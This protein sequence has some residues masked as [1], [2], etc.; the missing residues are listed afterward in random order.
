M[1]LFENLR[2]LVGAGEK[3]A[4][5]AARTGP[6]ATAGPVRVLVATFDGDAGGALQAHVHATLNGRTSM[7][8][9]PLGRPMAAAGGEAGARIA[10]GT[11][12]A[13]NALEK[14]GA[15]VLLWGEAVSGG[16][17][18]LRF[19]TSPAPA[20]FGSGAPAATE[21]LD[22]PAAFDDEQGDV[23]EMVVLACARPYDED[24]RK[25]RADSLRAA[26]TAGMRV[27]G[28]NGL[29][30]P[31]MTSVQAWLGNIA[32][33]P[34]LRTSMTDVET[35]IGRYRSALEAGPETMGEPMVA[36]IRLHLAAA[37]A[38]IASD[39]RDTAG[40][41]EAATLARAATAVITR[42]TL[43]EDYAAAQALLGWILHRLGTLANRTA[44]MREAVTAYQLACSV[45]TRGA[46]TARWAE[47]QVTIGR[48]LTTL[49]E[50]SS[51]GDFLDQAVS[52]FRGVMGAYSR[53]KAPVFWANLQNNI[54][55]ALFA[56]SKRSNSPADLQAA[57]TAYRE[58]AAVFEERRIDRSLAIVR[59]NLHRVERLA[60]LRDA[61]A[62]KQGPAKAE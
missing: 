23:L 32:L 2:R 21:H 58:A 11:R 62:Q 43:P 54:G 48:L 12:A 22:L 5:S 1:A 47:T 10:E 7:T 25:A 17:V 46:N 15:E 52:V 42:E 8:V 36:G 30:A 18:R 14:G 9:S 34:T 16:R 20:E 56:K 28:R 51:H 61:Q 53:E 39:R 26:V 45:W 31:C 27:I 6:R 40:M 44:Y 59:K 4:A 3:P 33:H 19:V 49:G 57:A 60:Q 41:E 29:P 13:R 24:I 55:S 35:A 38:A 50:F 37:L